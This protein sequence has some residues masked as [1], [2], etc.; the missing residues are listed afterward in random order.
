MK[1]SLNPIGDYDR[2]G[3]IS[4]KI[5]PPK[6]EAYTP[7]I[8]KRERMQGEV[9]RYFARFTTHT[10]PADITEVSKTTYT[11]LRKN[12]LYQTVKIRW[13]ITGKLEDE[14]GLPDI[15]TPVRLYTGVLTANRMST[16]LA[17]ETLSG[18]TE[19]ITDYKR[20]WE[21]DSTRR[22]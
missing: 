15:N 1:F 16:E 18:I 4:S 21:D 3:R 17:N 10:S 9:V 11:A 20:F 13:K 5:R 22:E 19:Y 6:L 8:T 12:S 2:V 7:Q 14:F